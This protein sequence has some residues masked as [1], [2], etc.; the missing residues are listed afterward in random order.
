MKSVQK[1]FTK[2]ICGLRQLSYVESQLTLRLDSLELMRWLL[3]LTMVYKTIL[4]H[5]DIDCPGLLELYDG[6]SVGG[7]PYHL[8]GTF[9]KSPAGYTFLPNRSTASWNSLTTD[10][11]NVSPLH[12]FKVSPQ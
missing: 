4:G 8:S 11:I 3:D 2:R 5:I 9:Y 7:H 10:I 1:R 12:A 6:P